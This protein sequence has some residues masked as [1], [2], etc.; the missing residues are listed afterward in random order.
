MKKAGPEARRWNFEVDLLL[1]AINNDVATTVI[2]LLFSANEAILYQTFAGDVASDI[3][4]EGMIQVSLILTVTEVVAT[5][6]RVHTLYHIEDYMRLTVGV[7]LKLLDSQIY[8]AMAGVQLNVVASGL[9]QML[10]QTVVGQIIQAETSIFY[11]RLADKK[12]LVMNVVV[13]KHRPSKL[14]YCA[15]VT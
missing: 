3:T 5:R 4:T 13:E 6:R 2:I 15:R 12:A 8:H 9:T 1:A 7:M 10:R 11:L 14:D